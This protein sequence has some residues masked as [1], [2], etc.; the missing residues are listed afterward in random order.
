RG[1]LRGVD[2]RLGQPGEFGRQRRDLVN[3]SLRRLRGDRQ[4]TGQES[5]PCTQFRD[6]PAHGFSKALGSIF[7]EGLISERL[8]FTYGSPFRKMVMVV[9]HLTP[10]NSL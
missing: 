1:I 9:G 2:D 8:A 4:K 6:E 3:G 7:G 10:S 5:Q